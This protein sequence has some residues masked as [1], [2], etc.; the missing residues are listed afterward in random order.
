MNN[1]QLIGRVGQEPQI[2]EGNNTRV[3]RFTLATTERGRKRPDGTKG[4]DITEW[5]SV[6]FFGSICS[7]IEQYVKKGDLISVRGRIHYDKYED[8]TTKVTKYRTDIIGADL[9]LLSKKAQ[10]DSQ[11]EPTA[12]PV[13]QF[14]AD[15]EDCPF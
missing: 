1:V 4:E 6:V 13:Q 12:E 9:E 5:H 10:S 2:F 8:A 11:A 15:T 7:V 14:K 3:A